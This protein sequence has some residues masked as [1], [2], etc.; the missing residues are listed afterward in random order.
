V[1]RC[2]STNA[3]HASFSERFMPPGPFSGANM[4]FGAIRANFGAYVVGLAVGVL[5]KTMM[6]A[7][8]GNSIMNA[9]QGEFVT[10]AVMAVLAIVV[11][12]AIAL[13]VR[14][15]ARR[16]GTDVKSDA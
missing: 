16:N 13:V 5:P 12:V 7:F 2:T 4:A 3:C 1:A 11:A 15:F 10:A 14:R 8:F 9:F 6:V